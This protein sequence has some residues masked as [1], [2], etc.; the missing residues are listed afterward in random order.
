MPA[1][2]L[3]SR[4]LFC[5]SFPRTRAPLYSAYAEHPVSLTHP[6]GGRWIPAFAETTK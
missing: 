2:A 4:L 6:H 5:S 3:L 1:V